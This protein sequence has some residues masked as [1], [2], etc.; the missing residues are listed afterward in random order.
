[1]ALFPINLQV[2]ESALGTVLRVLKGLPGIAKMDLMLD[3]VPGPKGAIRKPR[4][5]NGHDEDRPPI[6]TQ[7]IM[8]L[9]ETPNGLHL[10]QLAE[11]TGTERSSL[12]T[13]LTQLRKGGITETAGPGSHKLTERALQEVAGKQAAPALAL[14]QPE[15]KRRKGADIIMERL[16]QGPALR[17][18]LTS[19]LVDSHL[20]ASSINSLLHV[21][22][23]RKQI[24]YDDQ[25]KMYSLIEAVPAEVTPARG[26][27]RQIIVDYLN[28]HDGQAK[29]ADLNKLPGMNER[30]IDGMLTRLK[31]EK[32]VEAAGI[33]AV[34]FTKDA[35]K[36]LQA[37]A[38]KE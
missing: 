36:K 5:G 15:S 26:A 35:A 31:K 11:K 33:G 4:N 38:S 32:I 7:I 28:A 9:A 22:H 19:A 30:I 24:A 21:M 3:E 34:R 29:R 17:A 12:N 23:E 8:A 16:K 2:E 6:K 14:P 13:A 25:S 27:G 1:M 18:A 20:A 10:D 37:K